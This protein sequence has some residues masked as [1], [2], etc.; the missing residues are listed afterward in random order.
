MIQY[1]LGQ[2]IRA[3]DTVCSKD[4]MLNLKTFVFCNKDGMSY[5]IQSVPISHYEI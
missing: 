3:Q 1:Y 2:G 4:F 5:I